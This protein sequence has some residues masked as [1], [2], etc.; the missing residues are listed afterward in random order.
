MDSLINESKEKKRKGKKL[1]RKGG[2]N[3]IYPLLPLSLTFS[4]L[5][6]YMNIHCVPTILLFLC[7]GRINV[8]KTI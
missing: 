7:F 5:S 2:V 8:D 4:K 1:K 3:Y 6:M